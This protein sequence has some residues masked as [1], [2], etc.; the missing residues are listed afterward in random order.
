MT[1]QTLCQ[2]RC[3][4]CTSV[5]AAPT[6][7]KKQGNHAEVLAYEHQVYVLGQVRHLPMHCVTAVIRA[8]CS[9]SLSSSASMS[10]WCL[11]IASKTGWTASLGTARAAPTSPCRSP[12]PFSCSAVYCDTLPCR[13]PD[14]AVWS[15]SGYT[16]SSDDVWA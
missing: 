15:M 3:S 5:K 2:G 11:P 13:G 16:A 12:S 10:R 14:A 6:H 1:W 9:C 8:G 4:K 7:L